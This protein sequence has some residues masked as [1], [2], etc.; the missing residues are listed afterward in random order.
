ME[1]CVENVNILY[2]EPQLSKWKLIV[3]K[4]LNAFKSAT[5]WC[6]IYEIWDATTM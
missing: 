3:T 6:V 1:R 5:R 4:W 2:Y